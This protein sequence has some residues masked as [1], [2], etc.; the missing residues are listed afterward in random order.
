M[1]ERCF[2]YFETCYERSRHQQSHCQ[3]V[4][5]LSWLWR[6]LWTYITTG[7]VFCHHRYVLDAPSISDSAAHL[8]LLEFSDGR[9]KPCLQSLSAPRNV[10]FNLY[11]KS[12]ACVELTDVCWE[13]AYSRMDHKRQQSQP[14]LKLDM[15][16]RKCYNHKHDH[17]TLSYEVLTPQTG[18]TLLR[19]G[20]AN[21][22]NK[23][24]LLWTINTSE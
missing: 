13:L 23:A 1:V 6:C 20:D 9:R 8:I 17:Q 7:T 11:V 16:T 2:T 21:V 5:Y 10:H 24:R 22:W 3:S 4:I 14:D 19:V 15:G 12:I 18:Q